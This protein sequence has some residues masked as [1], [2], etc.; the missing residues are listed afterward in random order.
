VTLRPAPA[1]LLAAAVLAAAA[2]LPGPA[3]AQG[4]VRYVCGDRQADVAFARRSAVLTLDGR[5]IPLVAAPSASGARFEAPGDP[6]TSVWSKGDR[7]TIAVEGAELPECVEAPVFRA[8]GNEPGW[9]LEIAGGRLTLLLDYGASRVEAEAE[10][11]AEDR[12]TVPRLGLSV[13]AADRVC[14]DDATGMPHPRAVRVATPGGEL[15]GCGGDPADLLT[16]GPWTVVEAGGSP[17]PTDAGAEIRFADDGR[18]SGRSGCNAFTGPFRLT[19]EAL[20]LGPLAATRR[21]C[22]PDRMAVEERVLA[23]L[24][25][26]VGFDMRDDGALVLL[27]PSGPAVVARR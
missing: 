15:R 4:A 26:T 1:A 25:L 2:A 11:P 20:G 10:R 5:R 13:E 6:S 3:A 18:V 12:W 14:R 16:G 7:A 21:L 27:G 23:A 8:T 22:P 9:M 17:V 19:G 24:A